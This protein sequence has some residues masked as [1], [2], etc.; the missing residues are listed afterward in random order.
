MPQ[1]FPPE[2]DNHIIEFNKSSQFEKSKIFNKYIKPVFEK[3]IEN[4]I[5]VY[6][7]YNIGDIDSLKKDCLANLYETLHKFDPNKGAKAFSYFNV[8]AK[9]WFIQ[10]IRKS[11]K[12]NKIESEL[13]INFDHEIAKNDPNF[14][15]SP[16]EDI[17]EEKERWIKFYEEMELWRSKLL[18]KVEKQVLEAV[19]FLLK[20]N[21][22]ITI[23]SKKAVNLYLRELTG[24]TTKQ[25]A[26]NL[27]KIK[28]LY[29]EWCKEYNNTGK[30]NT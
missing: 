1:Y 19:I 13:Y 7:F 20:N 10:E 17:V 14:T 26:T 3:L 28:G 25:I 27:K 5:F 12:R 11:D 22:L 16:H 24:L 29:N 23:Y 4:L 18:K 8:I 9:N 21:E 15:V 6:K 30:T 2:T